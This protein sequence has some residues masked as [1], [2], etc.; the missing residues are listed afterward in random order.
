MPVYEIQDPKTGQTLKVTSNRQPTQEEAKNIFSQNLK[1]SL[2]DEALSLGITPF[3]MSNE[4]ISQSI[5]QQKQLNETL[6][7]QED[8]GPKLTESKLKKD[9]R[10][11]KAAKS[12]YKLNEGDEAPKLD[13]DEQYSDYALRYMGW[14]EYNLPKLGLEATQLKWATDDQKKEF[15]NL[16]DLYDQKSP[17]AA[18]FYRAVKGV[19]LDPTTYAGITSFG[20]ATA[21]AQATKQAIKEAIKTGTKESI[22]EAAQAGLKHGVKTG[23]MEGAAYTAIHNVGTQT[24]RINAG[25]QDSYDLSQIGQSAALGAGVGAGIGGAFGGVGA[26]ASAGGKL[27]PFQKKSVETIEPEIKLPDDPITQFENLDPEIKIRS[28]LQKQIYSYIKENPQRSIADVQTYFKEDFDK[29]KNAMESLYEKEYLTRPT[30]EAKFSIFRPTAKDDFVFDKDSGI[31]TRKI[32]KDEYVIAPTKENK[33]QVFKAEKRTQKEINDELDKAFLYKNYD[34]LSESQIQDVTKTLQK[35]K[36]NKP[37]QIFDSLESAKDYVETFAPQKLPPMLQQMKVPKVRTARQYLSRNI[38]PAFARRS[39]LID[40]LGGRDPRR[41]PVWTLKPKARVQNGRKIPQRGYRDFDEIQQAMQEDEFYPYTYE[42]EAEDLTNKIIDDIAD[43]RIHPI[44]KL[45]YDLAIQENKT[46]QDQ[47]NLLKANDYPVAKM[48][49]DEV[50]QALKDIES[51][52]TPPKW[53]T[54]DIPS[55]NL[56]NRRTFAQEYSEEFAKEI[57]SRIPRDSLYPDFEP[58][59]STEAYKKFLNIGVQFMEQLGIRPMQSEK[60]ITTQIFEA[61]SLIRSD[62]KFFDAFTNTLQRNNLSLD[63]FN[64]L[65]KLNIS[66]DARRMNAAGQA[67]KALEKRISSEAVEILDAVE[68]EMKGSPFG[69]TYNTIKELDNIRRGLMVSQIG[70]AVRNFYSLNPIRLGLH[71]LGRL[72][73][74]GINTVVNPVRSLFNKE[75]VPVDI[76]NVIGLLMNLSKDVK[77]AK[78]I[79]DFVLE[80]YPKQKFDLFTTYASEVADASTKNNKFFKNVQKG[81]DFLNIFNRIQEYYFRRGMFAT[82]LGDSLRKKGL[83]IKDIIQRNDIDAID[84]EDVNKAIKDALDFTYSLTPEAVKSVKNLQDAGNYIGNGFINFMNAAPFLTTA[85]FPFPRFIVNALRHLFEYSPLGFLGLISQ[86]EMQKIAKGDLNQ[87]SK[88]VVGSAILLGFIEA[89]RKGFGG[90]RWYELNGTDGTTIDTRPFFPVSAYL[91]A[92]DTIARVESGREPLKA[93]EI[94]EGVTGSTF[95][96]G[97][98][99]KLVDDVIGA[100]SGTVDEQRI[101]KKL[102]E[103]AGEVAS[104]YLTPIRQFNDFVDSQGFFPEE[105]KFRT[106]G[107]GTFGEIIQKNIP[108]LREQ[109]PLAESPTRAAAPGRPKRVRLPGT[110]ISLPGPLARQIFGVPVIEPKNVVEKEFDRLGFSRR[111]I[112]PYTGDK[113]LDQIRYKYYGPVIEDKLTEVINS[114]EYQSLTNAL[115]EGKLRKELAKIRSDKILNMAIMYEGKE[116]SAKY[117]FNRLPK[118]QKRALSRAGY[119]IE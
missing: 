4:Q 35:E 66:E 103:Y 87:L 96:F 116:K 62:E 72:V 91:L 117:Y 7:L 112:V 102:T 78:R 101:D 38:D 81:V 83:D 42:R 76:N 74:E 61:I 16:M 2:S 85:V 20:L 48:T 88:A 68:N 52:I 3:G 36:V 46:R 45:G 13:S 27:N 49:D 17:S 111:D 33:F 5:Q 79:T 115:K 110:D 9:P 99:L 64:Q 41:I 97:V 30:A 21:S 75:K 6:G 113:Q 98:G 55:E 106:T 10:W 28:P 70:T 26:Y 54:E 53:V 1:P 37:L 58:G 12:V 105:Q 108:F 86:K 89:K 51:G 69:L 90:E 82:S 118:W 67:K 32:K 43:D 18:G 77:S 119:K 60:K 92:A 71:T 114:E 29:V 47:V 104:T 63:E 44:D 57:K 8:T 15:I 56:L 31:L 23:A 11:I 80:A 50:V 100:V 39:E 22:K 93:R 94:L 25:A 73:N 14:F 40:A 34:N 59:I 95:R 65:A 24:A 109:L 19:L 84:Y 107:E